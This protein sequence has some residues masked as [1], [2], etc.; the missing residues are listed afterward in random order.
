MKRL[1]ILIAL[2]ASFHSNAQLSKE[3]ALKTGLNLTNIG[4][5]KGLTGYEFGIVYKKMFT[6]KI[7]AE[8]GLNYR[9][10]S[11]L[12]NV[13]GVETDLDAEFASIPI[14]GRLYI[15]KE[16]Y[17]RLGMQFSLITHARIDPVSGVHDGLN[18]D[19]SGDFN[20]LHFN[21]VGGFGYTLDKTVDIQLEFNYGITDKFIEPT[22]ARNTDGNN[23]FTIS[24]GWILYKE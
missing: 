14:A 12:E 4:D 13:K 3:F 20:F 10:Q 15:N 18:P 24:I 8:I 1:F 7:A 6:D 16:F 11:M 21:G 17:L 9:K 23:Y 2:L 22:I 5:E 19:I